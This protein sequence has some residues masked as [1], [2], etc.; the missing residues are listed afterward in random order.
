MNKKT[1]KSLDFTKLE[2][3]SIAEACYMVNCAYREGVGDR[4]RALWVDV[5]VSICERLLEAVTICLDT[6]NP[7]V[8]TQHNQWKKDKLRDGWKY[9]FI[10][11]VPKKEHPACVPFEELAA[12]H[13]VKG[14]L[15]LAT[16]YAVAKAIKASKVII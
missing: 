4:K 3:L 5:P 14:H 9:G 1:F 10:E 8:E 6:E 11:D 16:V 12:V 7:T 2:L 13:R 15:F